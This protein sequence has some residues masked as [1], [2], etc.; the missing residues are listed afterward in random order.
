MM[1]QKSAHI[2]KNGQIALP[3]MLLIGSIL[4]EIAIAGALM[5]YF[6]GS[7]RL[8]ERLYAR[9]GAIANT[10]VKNAIMNI[11]RDKD[12][13]SGTCLPTS[14]ITTNSDVASI[15]VCKTDPAGSDSYVYTILST[16]IAGGRQKKMEATVD[17]NKVTGE[18]EVIS[19]LER[20]VE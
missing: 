13:V 10:G 16:G 17:V 14:T 19:I 6:Y 7:S 5:M 8:A 3:F 9:A 4:I 1:F 15:V 2:K 11:S 20:Q 12:Y 18:V